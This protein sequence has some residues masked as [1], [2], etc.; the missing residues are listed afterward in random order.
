MAPVHY[1]GSKVSQIESLN[2][3]SKAV[4][5]TL[6]SSRPGNGTESSMTYGGS[7]STFASTQGCDQI[8]GEMVGAVSF[9]VS[10]MQVAGMPDESKLPSGTE[11]QI[12]ASGTS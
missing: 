3:A 1:I 4:S 6:S 7:N 9:L 8:L 12:W 11:G 10:S 2:A 5:G